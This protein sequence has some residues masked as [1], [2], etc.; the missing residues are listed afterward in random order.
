MMG[1]DD[2]QVLSFN[3][4]ASEVGRWRKLVLLVFLFKYAV[5]A[6][7]RKLLFSDWGSV[8]K[9]TFLVL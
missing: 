1:H 5:L 7:G 9:H 4:K 2:T 6:Q 8:E 3:L